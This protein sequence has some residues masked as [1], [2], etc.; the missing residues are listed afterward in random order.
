MKKIEQIVKGERVLKGLRNEISV[1]VIRR[2]EDPS[3]KATLYLEW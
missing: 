2:H 3:D 1:A